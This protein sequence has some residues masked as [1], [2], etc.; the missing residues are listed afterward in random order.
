MIISPIDVALSAI[1]V[2]GGIFL[3]IGIAEVMTKIRA[4][5]RRARRR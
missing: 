2:A 4:A 1:S 3:A 5:L